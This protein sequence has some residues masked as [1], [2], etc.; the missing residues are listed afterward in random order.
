VK[1]AVDYV[2]D[3][4]GLELS[5]E[6][7]Y[8]SGDTGESGTCEVDSSQFVVTATGYTSLSGR[9]EMESYVWKTGPLSVCLDAT[10]WDSYSSGIVTSSSCDQGDINHCVQIVFQAYDF[11]T[12][13]EK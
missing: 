9:S 10:T 6:Y 4:G 2:M 1:T 12:S 13:G 11:A 5:D 3:A 7:P 8:I